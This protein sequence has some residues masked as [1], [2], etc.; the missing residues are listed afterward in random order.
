MNKPTN[1]TG[2]QITYKQKM[3]GADLFRYVKAVAFPL[4]VFVIA[5]IAIQN[6]AGFGTK[7]VAPLTG[8]MWCMGV[9]CCFLLP[10]HRTSILKETHMTI[11]IYLITLVALKYIVAMMSGVS[12][13][14]LMEAFNQAIPTTSGS[15]ISG[16]LQSLMWITAVMT[17]VGFIGMQGKR[18]FSFRRKAAKEKFME[19]TRGVRSNGGEHMK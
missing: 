5:L 13:E 1:A 8:I 15:A 12:S 2:Q 11:G 9:V 10:S 17:P 14:M 16:W 6:L 3:S 18:V 19:Q 4:A 7:L